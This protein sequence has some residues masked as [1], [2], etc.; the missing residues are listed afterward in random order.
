MR[1]RGRGYGRGGRRGEEQDCGR[2]YGR[3]RGGRSRQGFWDD[4][5][6]QA[7]PRR[8]RERFEQFLGQPPEEHWMFGRR[9]FRPWQRGMAFFNPF[10]SAIF[11]R[12]GGL[13]PL[14]VLHLLDQEPR[15]GNELMNIIAERTAG[16]WSANPGAIYPLLNDLEEYGLIA[17][18]WEDPQRRTVRRYTITESGRDELK[19]LKSVIHPKLQEAIDVLSGISDEL[20][21]EALAEKPVDAA[22]TDEKAKRGE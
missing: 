12:R 1:N 8:W 6:G 11:S 9:R 21:E 14:Y 20:G 2:G 15:Y 5:Y 16:G 7:G 17:G 3:G 4:D 22:E 10:V 18:E 19:R 13:L